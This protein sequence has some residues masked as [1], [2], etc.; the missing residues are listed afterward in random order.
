MK[1]LHWHFVLPVLI[2]LVQTSLRGVV[3]VC[4]G[5]IIYY[6][7]TM[8]FEC[9]CCQMLFCGELIKLVLNGFL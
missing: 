7:V 1:P 6:V 9:V 8:A 4:F 3:C 5:V 2:H